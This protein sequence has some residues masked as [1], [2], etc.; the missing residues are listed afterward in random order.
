MSVVCLFVSLS[1]VCLFVSLSVVY[2]SRLLSVYLSHCLLFVYLSRLLSVYLSHCYLFVDIYYLFISLWVFILFC[3]LEATPPAA[4]DE[5]EEEEM[6]HIQQE[7]KEKGEMEDGTQ[8]DKQVCETPIIKKNCSLYMKNTSTKLICIYTLLHELACN[9]A[10][11][12]TSGRGI[13]TS[14]RR[15]K[16]Q[17][18]SAIT[19]IC[20]L[21]SVIKY[22]L[23]ITTTASCLLKILTQSPQ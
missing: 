20:T 1:V 21:T 2:L 9:I 17:P 13:F 22:L 3:F 8:Q 4:E 19:A 14:L 23:S 6:T 18:T 15:V 7:D 16:M 5:G 11:Y 12:C 10:S